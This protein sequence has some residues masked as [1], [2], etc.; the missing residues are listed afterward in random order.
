MWQQQQISV[1]ISSIL[2]DDMVLTD[3][4]DLFHSEKA[5]AIICMTQMA[6]PV[7]PAAAD[8]PHS[9]PDDRFIC[10]AG[11]AAQHT[12]LKHFEKR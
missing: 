4:Q 2:L 7:N 5:N 9:G 10:A 6:Q 1:K 8:W 12:L 3:S 11:N